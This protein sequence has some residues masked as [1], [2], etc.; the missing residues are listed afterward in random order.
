MTP[1]QMVKKKP[2]TFFSSFMQTV[3]L[4]DQVSSRSDLFH[5]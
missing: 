3:F 1:A 5:I 2:A 4:V